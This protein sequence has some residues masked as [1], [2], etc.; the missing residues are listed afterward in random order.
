[1][2]KALDVPFEEK[3]QFFQPGIRQPSFLAFSPTGKVPCL[4][5]SDT[6][7]VV[8]DSLAICEYIAEKYPAAWPSDL[9]ARTFARC[10]VA[11]MHSGF[12]ALRDECSMNVGLKIE[13]GTPGDALQRDIDRLSVLF[14]QGLDKFDGPWLAGKD[15]TVVDA[16][17]A[18]VA[19]RCKTFGIEL[20]G[21][22]K[23]YVERLFEH[24]AVQ[25]WVQDGLKE[26]AREPYHEDDVLRGRKILQDLTK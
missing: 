23:D 24:P 13:L 12:N 21:A 3:L 26:T 4:H 7:I 11:E 14:N 18:P 6:S 19:S 25:A 1:M 15:F 8:W 5:D 16:M 22:A 17:F 10:A 2:L 9:A 20:E